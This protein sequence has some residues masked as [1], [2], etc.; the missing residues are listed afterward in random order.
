M[1]VQSHVDC[2]LESTISRQYVAG[3]CNA[4]EQDLE[5][6]RRGLRR[7]ELRVWG[8]SVERVSLRRYCEFLEWL[9]V[10][11]SRP[12]LGLE[13]SQCGGPER[14]G[15]IGYL[16][17]GSR[18]LEVAL[19]GFSHYIGEVQNA[20]EMILEKDGEFASYEYRVDDNRITHRRQDSECSL[21]HCW[22][23]MKLFSGNTCR[24]ALVE[25]EHDRP[26]DDNKQCERTFNAPVLF[27]QSSNRLH[28]RT[29]ALSI[30]SSFG[31]H[32]LA[33]ILEEQLEKSAPRDADVQSFSSQVTSTIA[34]Y[35]LQ[36]GMGAKSIAG[37]LGVSETTLYRRL[38]LENS[39]FKALTDDMRKSLA[40]RLLAS[41]SV[42][43]GDVAVRLGYADSACLTRAFY[44]WFD[45]SPWTYRQTYRFRRS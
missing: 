8:A 30:C 45:M 41:S 15:T 26:N 33:P 22:K 21:G 5:T 16:F 1:P 10:E 14:M 18:T 29:D 20:S 25:F 27:G 19:R 11:L 38:A 34:A 9:A 40:T 31:D 4:L 35:G 7:F 2:P 24:L 13:L 3:L 17:L 36:R 42:S 6:V 12:H 37:V 23:L 32:H 43:I 28:F 44:R 39:S